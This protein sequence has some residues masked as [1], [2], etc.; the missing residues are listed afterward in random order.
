M[1]E[2]FFKDLEQ[3]Y[4][5]IKANQKEISG[6][7]DILGKKED[8]NKLKFINTFLEKIGLEETSENQMAAISRLVS[9]RDDSL[10]Q[11]LKK[12]KST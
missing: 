10:S 3:V 2:K 6:F 11:S 8:S 12:A 9:L 7:Y 5:L 4:Q 1:K